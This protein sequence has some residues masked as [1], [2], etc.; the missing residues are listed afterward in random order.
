MYLCLVF[1]ELIEL[2][3]HTPQLARGIVV[4]ENELKP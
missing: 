3:M 4:Y 1:A 2:S